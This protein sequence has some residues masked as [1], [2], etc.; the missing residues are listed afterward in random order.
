MNM[1]VRR[2]NE[3]NY[4]FKWDINIRGTVAYVT[5]QL[6]KA[7]LVQH[8]G[9]IV[10]DES[11]ESVPRSDGLFLVLNHHTILLSVISVH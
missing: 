5:L 10:F 2:G 7:W 3:K 1:G 4:S 6:A 8:L 9:L 11:R